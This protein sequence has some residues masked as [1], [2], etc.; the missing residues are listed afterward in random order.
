MFYHRIGGKEKG[1]R[2]LNCTGSSLSES[3]EGDEV[4]I[5]AKRR[6]CAK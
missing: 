2:E 4:V 1:I 6:V 5:L 3:D